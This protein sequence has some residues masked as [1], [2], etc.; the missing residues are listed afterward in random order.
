MKKYFTFTLASFA[1]AASAQSGNMPYEIKAKAKSFADNEKV[2]L[3]VL[4]PDTNRFETID[5]T[6]IKKGS[7]HFKGT[8]D[9]LAYASIRIGERANDLY[10]EKGTINVAIEEVDLTPT[11]FTVSGTPTNEEFNS[12]RQGVIALQEDAF[13]F[14]ENNTTLIEEAIANKDNQKI[15]SLSTIF[16]AKIE[17]LNNFIFD[18]FNNKPNSML[19]ATILY[20]RITADNIDKESAVDFYSKLDDKIKETNLGQVLHNIITT[21]NNSQVMVGDLAPDFTHKDLNGKEVTLSKSLGEITILHFWAPWCPA[22]QETM[23]LIKEINETYKDKGLKVIGIALEQDESQVKETVDKE[24]LNWSQIVYPNDVITMYAV[25]TIPTIFI[26][27]KKGEV[28]Y[29]D[30]LG[31]EAKDILEKLLNK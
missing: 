19:S 18:Q 15:D 4:S 23:P 17:K 14:R 30:N 2:Y 3:E 9:N 13:N 12:F 8:T 1:L 20:Q 7:F 10:L 11:G 29:T 25:R 22:C 6:T 28:I 21:N 31:P 26:L 24:H 27:D 16:T 5:S